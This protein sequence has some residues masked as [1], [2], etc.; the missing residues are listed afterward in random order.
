MCNCNSKSDPKSSKNDKAKQIITCKLTK[1][2]LTFNASYN[3]GSKKS[4]S[5][6]F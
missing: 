3:D 5:C 4:V 1:F 2:V 6:K